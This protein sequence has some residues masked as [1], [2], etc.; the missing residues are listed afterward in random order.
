MSKTLHDKTHTI[1]NGVTYEASQ[2]LCPH[3]SA[4]V[5][6]NSLREKSFGTLQI[7]QCLDSWKTLLN[8]QATKR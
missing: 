4:V 8:S 1:D 5:F 2:K 3:E 6:E 7:D